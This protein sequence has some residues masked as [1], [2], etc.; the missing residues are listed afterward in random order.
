[1]LLKSC[2]SGGGYQVEGPPPQ[3]A[4]QMPEPSE[5]P[6]SPAAW[7]ERGTQA[8]GG[9]RLDLVTAPSACNIITSIFP[10]ITSNLFFFI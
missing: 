7:A 6:S 5:F 9:Q 2:Y 10:E 8:V 1:M 3:S 4:Y